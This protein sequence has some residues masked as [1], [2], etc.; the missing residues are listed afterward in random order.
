MNNFNDLK[1]TL[2][3]LR[4]PSFVEHFSAL[5]EKATAENATHIDYL[6]E[7]AVLEYD[8]R[9][10]RRIAKNLQASALPKEKTLTTFK[11]H[12]NRP[13]FR[14][15][16]RPTSA[17]RIGELPPRKNATRTPAEQARCPPKCRLGERKRAQ[18]KRRGTPRRPSCRRVTV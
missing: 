18:P 1:T 4:L 13:S 17:K 14:R 5:A 12:Q 2:R 10:Q 6:H 3:G 9:K 16:N 11:N 8:G 7:L 15:Q